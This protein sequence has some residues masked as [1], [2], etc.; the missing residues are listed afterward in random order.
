MNMPIEK[1][2][3]SEVLEVIHTIK[4]SEEDIVGAIMDSNPPAV[5]LAELGDTKGKSIL[6]KSASDV[7]ILLTLAQSLDPNRVDFD[8][9]I[10][11]IELAPDELVVVKEMQ[12][13]LFNVMAPFILSD[14]MSKGVPLE[15]LSCRINTLKQLFA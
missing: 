14:E 5:V 7:M 12:Q 11:L 4:F 3:A 8:Q 2:H 15:T 6:V 13:C 1:I 9:V 10:E